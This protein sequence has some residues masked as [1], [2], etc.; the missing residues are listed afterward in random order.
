MINPDDDLSGQIKLIDETNDGSWLKTRFRSGRTMAS[1]GYFTEN[2]EEG[3]MVHGIID[4]NF[5]RF[6]NSECHQ[7]AD[8]EEQNPLREVN[9]TASMPGCSLINWNEDA[10]TTFDQNT[11]TLLDKSKRPSV[12]GHE[13]KRPSNVARSSRG[14]K[15]LKVMGPV[16]LTFEEKIKMIESMDCFRKIKTKK[17]DDTILVGQDNNDESDEESVNLTLLKGFPFDR[18]CFI[19][20]HMYGD[21]GYFRQHCRDIH[22]ICS[23]SQ[24][25]EIACNYCGQTFSDS[26]SEN[27]QNHEKSA[28]HDLI[29]CIKK[30]EIMK[31]SSRANSKKNFKNVSAID[32]QLQRQKKKESSPE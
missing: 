30:K 11:E 5:V 28:K 4:E 10:K 31:K 9:P 15:N 3:Q 14:G 22:N 13:K 32:L 1:N 8:L 2:Q 26:K 20:D 21:P 12:S 24:K 19:C 6:I 29:Y 7:Q 27:Y 16:N 25:K 23:G 18:Y 17:S